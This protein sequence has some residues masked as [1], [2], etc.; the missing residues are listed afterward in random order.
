MKTASTKYA[1]ESLLQ[2]SQLACRGH[3]TSTWCGAGGWIQFDCYMACLLPLLHFEA[4]CS[5]ELIL[6]RAL[7]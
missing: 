4:V 3:N 2:M 7:T 1:F 6:G 5:W